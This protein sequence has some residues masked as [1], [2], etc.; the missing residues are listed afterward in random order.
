MRFEYLCWVNELIGG[1]KPSQPLSLQQN[2]LPVSSSYADGGAAVGS[3]STAT[4]NVTGIDIG[5]GASCVFPL[6]G[7]AAFGWH[8]LASEVD[9]TSLQAAMRNL[10]A[11]NRCASNKSS[12]SS[13]SSSGGC[14]G[15]SRASITVDLRKVALLQE[16]GT[17]TA[18]DD[19]PAARPT[20]TGNGGGGSLAET[21]EAATFEL[22]SSEL[23]KV[24]QVGPPGPLLSLIE[25]VDAPGAATSLEAVSSSS[26]TAFPAPSVLKPSYTFCVVN[27]PFFSSP[28]EAVR[29]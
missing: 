4:T 22:S 16:Q 19:S 15:G 10:E 20:I 14:G 27:P 29:R 13:S 2:S 3:K 1:G 21:A 12:S 11:A 6:L 26:S 23:R 28:Q 8:W 18:D 5:T 24:E 7:G 17:S 9:E 25:Q